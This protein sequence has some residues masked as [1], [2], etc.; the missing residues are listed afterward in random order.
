VVEKKR[1]ESKNTSKVEQP[2]QNQSHP[3]SQQPAQ[4]AEVIMTKKLAKANKQIE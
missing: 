3:S 4:S 1:A 2:H